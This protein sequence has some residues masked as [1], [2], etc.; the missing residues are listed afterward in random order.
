MI[1]KGI[2]C[3]F[4]LFLLAWPGLGQEAKRALPASAKTVSIISVS[5]IDALEQRIKAVE[6]PTLRAFLYWQSASWLAQNR[7]PATTPRLLNL[8]ETALAYYQAN[9]KEMGPRDSQYYF[10]LVNIAEQL[11]AEEATKWREKYALQNKFDSPENKA[12]VKLYQAIQKL[13]NPAAAAQS[14]ETIRAVIRSGQVPL[15]N[16]FGEIIRFD[17][18]NSPNLFVLLSATLDW[19]EQ[20]PGAVPLN[21]LNFFS[22]ICVKEK[23]PVEIRLRLFPV[24]LRETRPTP[25]LLNNLQD[26]Q[27]VDYMYLAVLPAMQKLAPPLYAEGAAQ[28]AALRSNQSLASDP[29]LE[30][31]RRIKESEDPLAQTIAEAELV[32]DGE[33]KG[34]LLLS[35]T[36]LAREQGK[37]RQAVQLILAVRRVWAGYRSGVDRDLDGIIQEALNKQEVETA[38]YALAEIEDL[39]RR[40]DST[41]RLARY[42]V[43]QKDTGKAADVLQEAA[44]HLANALTGKEKALAYAN[45]ALDWAG[46][47]D[48]QFRET[49][50]LLVKSANNIEKPDGTPKW[51]FNEQLTPLL[52]AEIQVFAKFAGKDRTGALNMTDSFN[53]T[54][55]RAAALLGVYQGQAAQKLIAIN[56]L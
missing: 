39:L 30:I 8:S 11:D 22:S 40:A 1:G 53:Y 36:R 25:A 45:L 16:Y 50:R 21:L 41:R 42:F 43:T 23:V 26:L 31:N 24:V 55:M 12:S 52:R 56:G 10:G 17:Q 3:N 5:E 51:E 20:A 6:S 27:S 48:F 37:L 54:E 19:L 7:T 4:L 34:G 35:A 29:R 33:L 46:L 44:K 14:A 49:V 2:L 15:T 9:E 28:Y 13:N 38:R 18:T 32:K 47:D